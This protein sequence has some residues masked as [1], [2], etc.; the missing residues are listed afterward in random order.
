MDGRGIW[1]VTWSSVPFGED[2]AI[3][4]GMARLLARVPHLVEEEN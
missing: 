3:G 2:E 4:G 1:R